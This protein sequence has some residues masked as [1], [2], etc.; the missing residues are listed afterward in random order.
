LKNI[1]FFSFFTSLIRYTNLRD[2]EVQTFM[3][4]LVERLFIGSCREEKTFEYDD[5]EEGL[6]K[7]SCSLL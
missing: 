7:L 4:S 6:L 3:A 1:D 2:E 5:F